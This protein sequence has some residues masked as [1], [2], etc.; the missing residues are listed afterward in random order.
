MRLMSIAATV[1]VGRP[2]H[3]R[4][5]FLDFKEARRLEGAF[6][7]RAQLEWVAQCNN[8]LAALEGSALFEPANRGLAAAVVIGYRQC[9]NSGSR[10]FR[11]TEHHI[12]RC[13]AHSL[14]LHKQIMA[15]ANKAIAHAESWMDE[16][17]VGMYLNQRGEFAG[18]AT[19]H[20]RAAALRKDE[21]EQLASA[22]VGLDRVLSEEIEALSAKCVAH[23][24]ALSEQERLTADGVA[25]MPPEVTRDDIKP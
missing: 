6:S 23:V 9:F 4:S 24:N 21:H 20:Q 19:Q 1:P 5:H 25:L 18:L 13:A 15:V 10:K 8:A 2:G 12:K 11:L 22:L 16:V 17:A 14:A 3:W 7:V